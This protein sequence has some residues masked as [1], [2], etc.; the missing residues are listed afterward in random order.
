MTQETVM[1][2]LKKNGITSDVQRATTADS[3][4]PFKYL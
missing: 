3:D 4:S 1:N 2:S